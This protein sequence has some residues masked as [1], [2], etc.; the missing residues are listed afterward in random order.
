MK[1]EFFFKKGFSLYRFFATFTE[2]TNFGD[3]TASKVNAQHIYC[4]AQ[5]PDAAKKMIAEHYQTMGIICTLIEEVLPPSVTNDYL[6]Y[7]DKPKETL[8][9]TDGVTVKTERAKKVLQ[10]MDSNEDAPEHYQQFVQQIASEFK[11]SK[12]QLEAE[13]EPFI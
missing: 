2:A 13:L 6:P 9:F 1:E 8:G 12:E 11:I 5:D 3:D 4:I 7:I 10:L